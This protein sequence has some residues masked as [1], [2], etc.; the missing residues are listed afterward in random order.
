MSGLAE[1]LANDTIVANRLKNKAPY[2]YR[3]DGTPK[4]R[5]FL[6]LIP[7]SQN[8]VMSEKSIGVDFDGRNT[9]IPTIVPTLSQEEI[10]HLGS[11]KQITE[12]IKRKAIDHALSR[13][14][15]GLSPFAD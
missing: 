1:N 11:G 5:G 2:G 9:L 12:E 3:E 15:Q 4:G 7:D 14:R 6:G 10:N 13:M 8:N